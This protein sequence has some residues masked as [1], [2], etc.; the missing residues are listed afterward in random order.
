[1]TAF[2][3]FLGVLL[4]TG[5]VARLVPLWDRGGRLLKQFPTEDGYLMLTIARNLAIGKGFSVADGEIATNG[6]QPLATLVYALVFRIVDGDRES[7]VAWIL[8]L[9]VVIATATAFGLYRLGRRALDQRADA[10]VIASL[11]ACAWFASPVVLPHTMNCLETGAYALIAVLVGSFLL[12][13]N[14]Q[15]DRPWSLPRTLAFGLLLGVAF[16]VRNDACFLVL[17]ACLAYLAGGLG[18]N[19]PVLMVRLGRVLLFGVVSV[20]VASPWLLF[21]YL[22]FG[23]IV[24][25]SGRAEAELGTFAGN[26]S[27]VPA[28]LLRYLA[29]FL[30]IPQRLAEHPLVLLGCGSVLAGVAFVL[31]RF[32]RRGTHPERSVLVLAVTHTLGL[33]TFYGV[34]FGAGWFMTRYLAPLSVFGALLWA[35]LMVHGARRALVR[36]SNAFVWVGAL[37]ILLLTVGLDVR[38]YL[39]GSEHMHFQVVQWVEGHVPPEVWIGAVQTGTVGFFHDRTIN[40]DGKVNRFAHEAITEGRIAEYTV[41]TPAEYLADWVGILDWLS[42]PLIAQNFEVVVEDRDRNLGV[43]KRRAPPKATG[44]RRE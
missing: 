13:S 12:G 26:L 6:T 2:H 25:V 27:L 31:G 17:G 15:P 30:P 28:S 16:W 7:G 41:S 1:V 20:L 14:Q 24:P 34:F 3:A 43:L 39:R 10:H 21:N 23:H 18:A 32:W 42:M 8:V 11:A 9:Q 29:L 22:H 5:L 37:G 44:S 40:L 4:A 19:R 33:V 38:G 36:G 35:I